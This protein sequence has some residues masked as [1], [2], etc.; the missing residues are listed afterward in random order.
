MDCAPADALTLL[1]KYDNTALVVS[2]RKYITL[3][4]AE[5][6]DRLLVL[7]LYLCYNRGTP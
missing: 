1:V 5:Q 3:L 7:R 6:T 2:S 4:R